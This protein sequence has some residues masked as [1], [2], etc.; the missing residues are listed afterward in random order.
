MLILLLLNTLQGAIFQLALGHRQQGIAKALE[1]SLKRN[2]PNQDQD[3]D[4]LLSE[5]NISSS[6]SDSAAYQ[7]VLELANDILFYLSGDAFARHFPGTTY[8]YHLNE[9]NP[10]DGPFKGQATHILDVALLFRNFDHELPAEAK[11]VGHA[12]G[13]SI[14]KFVSGQVPWQ[15][16]SQ[17]KPVAQV[18]GHDAGTGALRIDVSEKVGRRSTVFKY[19]D[20]IGWDTLNDAFGAF[21]AGR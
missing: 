12:Y 14:I 16:T 21:L 20:T 7:S 13:D 19:K 11:E 15:A 2:I 17:S 6:T 5:Y 8:V 1:M 4:S 9:P 18:F 3:I 10:W